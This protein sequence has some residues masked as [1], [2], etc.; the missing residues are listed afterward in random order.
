MTRR[1][2]LSLLTLIVSACLVTSLLGI[3]GLIFFS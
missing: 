2:A 3:L 1:L